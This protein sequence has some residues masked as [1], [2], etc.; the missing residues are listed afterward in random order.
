MPKKDAIDYTL[1]LVT[2]STPEIL[3]NRDICQVVEDAIAGGVTIVQYR[4][5][6]SDTAVL[7]QVAQRLHR[8]TSSRN[9]PLLINDRVDVALA[10][11]C[12]GVHLGQDD[13]CLET[14]RRLLGPDAIIGISASTR[15]EALEACKNGSDYLG[16]GAVFATNTKTNTKH[17]L[18]PAGVQHLL[19]TMHNKGFGHVQTVAIGGINANNIQRVFF[20]CSLPSKKLLDGVAIVS[21]IMAAPDPREATSNLLRLA[22]EP[23][24]ALSNVVQAKEPDEII[25]LVPGIIKAVHGSTPLSHNMTNLVVQNFAANVALAVGASPIMANYGE[26]AADLAKLGGALVINMG[27]VTPEGIENYTKALRAYNAAERP[28][29]FDPVGAGATAVRREAVRAILNTGHV[30]VIKG[31]EGEIAATLACTTPFSDGDDVL[32]QQRGVDSVSSLPDDSA[33]AHLA[34]KLAAQQRGSVIVMTGPTDIVSDGERTFAVV[35]HG[36]PILGR[37]TGTGCCLGTVISA[38][39]CS[40]TPAG[41]DKLVAVISG[42]LLYEIAA[43]VAAGRCQGPGSFVPA[44]IDA[45]DETRRAAAEGDVKWMSHAK[46]VRMPPT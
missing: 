6:T 22:K 26:E 20:R 11:G 16:I 19:E 31:N 43:E 30:S 18:G 27:T 42:I 24:V 21:A 33:R 2:D 38:M 5:K 8:I 7:I 45:L 25:A 12:E 44:F 40:G 9:V 23:P 35:G 1:Y 41:T 10:I 29:V 15:E 37:V 34:A 28:V 46:I 3:G 39:L 4:D 32:P 14:A 13:M 17:I 36:H